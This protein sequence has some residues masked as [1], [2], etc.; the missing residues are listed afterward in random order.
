MDIEGIETK[1]GAPISILLITFGGCSY[2]VVCGDTSSC[3]SAHSLSHLSISSIFFHVHIISLS[4]WEVRQTARRGGHQSASRV[5]SSSIYVTGIRR[6]YSGTPYTATLWTIPC[7]ETQKR[8]ADMMKH[9]LKLYTRLVYTN[10]LTQMCLSVCTVLR[11]W[12][13]WR[14]RQP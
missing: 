3:L 13:Q 11:V 8:K 5:V 1:A 7:S 12:N 9:T 2:H 10:L 14:V 4:A 6:R